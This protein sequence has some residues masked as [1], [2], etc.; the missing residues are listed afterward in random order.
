MSLLPVILDM[1]DDMYTTLDS[2]KGHFGEI[3][4]LFVPQPRG[5]LTRRD[6][7]MKEWKPTTDDFQAVLNVKSF[8]PEEVSVKVKGREIIVEGKHE[9][10]HDEQGLC[11]VSRQFSRRYILP[12]EFDPDTVA[13]YLD[14][15]GKMTIKALKPKPVEE[16]KN[17]RIIPIERVPIEKEKAPVENG[18]A[19]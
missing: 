2:S 7:S 19:K 16:E 6:T 4:L 12:E 9:E 14:S 1:V 8:R 10:R 17:E 11:F 13:T 3:P 15:K 5:A 18:D